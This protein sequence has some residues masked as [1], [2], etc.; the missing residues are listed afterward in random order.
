TFGAE[1]FACLVMG[2]GDTVCIEDNLI[3]RLK[4]LAAFGVYLL[5]SEAQ[6][7]SAD[8]VEHGQ[9]AVPATLEP[10]RVV[11]GTGVPQLS[12][13]RVVDTVESGDERARRVRV[14]AGQ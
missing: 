13:G 5:L 1:H 11:A 12:F 3:A 7:K 14:P 4:L 2:F 8:A 9:R 10:R 6:R